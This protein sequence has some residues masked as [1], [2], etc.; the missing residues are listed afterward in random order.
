M[1][2]LER[3]AGEHLRLAQPRVVLVT[4]A[5]DTSRHV[6]GLVFDG[7]RLTAVI[8]V[9]RQPGDDSGLRREAASLARLQELGARDD[10]PRLL[11]LL[12]VG[13]GTALLETALPGCPLGPERVRA[14]P[15]LLVRT[16]TALVERLP[17]TGS[18]PS[19]WYDDLVAAP[20]EALRTAFPGLVDDLVERTHDAL[21]T[22]RD[23][24]LPAVFEHGDLSHPNLLLVAPERLGA[25]DWER[26]VEYGLP[27]HDLTYLLAYVAEARAAAA[28][29]PE[30]MT[31]IAAA[32]VEEGGWARPVLAAHL[33]RQGVDPTLMDALLLTTA[34]RGAATVAGRLV[35][36]ERPDEQERLALAHRDRDVVLWRML[37]DGRS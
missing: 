14:D 7:P 2:L 27:G 26:S 1:N 28:T 4:P 8:K 21:A 33:A 32:L 24:S 23:A 19:T 16:G 17:T 20:I 22:L 37:L 12:P 36:V 5:Y 34:A 3:L 11:A 18:H 30:R 10:A 29:L 25:V 6:V 31:A 13:D 15:G 9:C 35:S